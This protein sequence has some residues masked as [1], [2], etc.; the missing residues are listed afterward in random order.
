[1]MNSEFE[2]NFP[3]MCDVE[4]EKFK[5]FIEKHPSLLKY[6]DENT[7]FYEDEHFTPSIIDETQFDRQVV[8]EAIEKHKTIEG[9]NPDYVAGYKQALKDIKKDLFG[10]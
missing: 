7:D 8:K 4:L 2:K 6:Y 9:D 5:K 10:E 3:N 1:M